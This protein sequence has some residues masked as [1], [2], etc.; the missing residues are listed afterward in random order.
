MNKRLV[1]RPTRSSYQHPENREYRMV[2]CS[3]SFFFLGESEFPHEDGK[4]YEMGW[5][6]LFFFKEN[7]DNSV[8]D[9]NKQKQ[10]L[11]SFH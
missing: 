10:K 4:K 7:A 6:H 1:I 9:Q 11:D 3:Y 5:A 8:L 2:I